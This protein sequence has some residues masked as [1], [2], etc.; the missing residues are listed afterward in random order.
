MCER[1]ECAEAV[2]GNKLAEALEARD[3]NVKPIQER[4]QQASREVD[5][6]KT[7]PLLD[8]KNCNAYC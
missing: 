7:A 8:P 3:Y 5:S 6:S 1:L 4:A 2:K